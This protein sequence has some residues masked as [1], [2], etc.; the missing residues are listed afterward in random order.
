MNMKMMNQYTESDENLD[1][2]YIVYTLSSVLMYLN[3]HPKPNV[4]VYHML[5]DCPPFLEHQ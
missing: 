2:I 5:K 4:G 1:L 3:L